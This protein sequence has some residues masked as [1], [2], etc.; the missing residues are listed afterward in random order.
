MLT[1]EFYFICPYCWQTI[2]IVI[3]RKYP[4]HEYIEDCEVCCRPI[5]FDFVP[6]EESGEDFFEA[7]R[8]D[9]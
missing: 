4:M 6:N 3:D 1:E 8:L 7:K 9:D 5:A 2:S